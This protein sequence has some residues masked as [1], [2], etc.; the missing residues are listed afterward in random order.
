[1]F[2]MKWSGR[3][4]WGKR[5]ADSAVIVLNLFVFLIALNGLA[6]LALRLLPDEPPP[7][8]ARKPTPGYVSGVVRR[9]GYNT[10]RPRYPDLSEDA[11]KQL[12]WETWSR[13]YAYEPYTEFTE[14]AFEGSYVNI[15]AAGFRV[16]HEQGPWPPTAENFNVF[17]LGGSTTFGYGLSDQ[18]ALGSALQQQ[19]RTIRP[20][21]IYNFGRAYYFSTQERILFESLLNDGFVPDAAIF[22]DGLNDF[23]FPSGLPA[24]FPALAAAFPGKEKRSPTDLWF[25]DLAAGRLFR[26]LTVNPPDNAGGE[27]SETII[28]D[29]S[30]GLSETA[31]IDR[32]I[33]RYVR[34]RKLEEAAAQAFGVRTLFVWQPVPNYRN[35]PDETLR[36]NLREHEL[37]A[38]GY[39]AMRA[40]LDGNP[41]PNLVW[42]ADIMDGAKGILYVDAVHYAPRGIELLAQCIQNG[43]DAS[44]LLDR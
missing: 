42:C 15:A 44:R 28:I 13:Q 35:Q 26:R 9:Y 29:P 17:L 23:A 39:P 24:N 37:S 14:R 16:G 3:G 20:V 25:R 41:L 11:F 32:V 10:I 12:M 38:K 18:E 33:Q 1:M 7:P 31:K 22:V 2:K 8:L 34:N 40:Y 4:T 5:Y 19:L 27:H 43:A 21:K 36:K 6:W 30:A